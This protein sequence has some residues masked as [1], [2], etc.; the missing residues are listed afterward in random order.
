VGYYPHI[1]NVASVG[2][3]IVYFFLLKRMNPII[4]SFVFIIFPVFAIVIDSW[5]DETPLSENFIIFALILLTGF[6]ITKF[7]VEMLF[8]SKKG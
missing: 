1:I 3:F 7:P 6:A 4:L 5:Y 2:G 8:T